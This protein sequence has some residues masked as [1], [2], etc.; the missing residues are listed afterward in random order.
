MAGAHHRTTG[1]LIHS[2]T[3]EPAVGLD[4]RRCYFCGV[5]S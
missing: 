2:V 1:L 5:L 4:Q 3:C